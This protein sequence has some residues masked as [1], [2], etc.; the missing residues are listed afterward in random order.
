MRFLAFEPQRGKNWS[1]KQFVFDADPPQMKSFSEMIDATNPDLSILKKR[2][3][4]IIHYHGWADALVNSQMS[5]EYYES[6]MKKMGAKET[7]EFYKLYM[8]PGMFHCGGGVGCDRVDWFAPLVNWVE[9]GVA[10]DVLTGS[11]VEKGA[12]TMTRPHCAYPEVA[13]YKGSGDPN[14]AESFT[15][16]IEK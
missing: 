11:R 8:I 14:K 5:V 1:W 6:V 9:K 13:K 15:C 7:K 12:T 3:G 16:I 10:P 2:G 4:K